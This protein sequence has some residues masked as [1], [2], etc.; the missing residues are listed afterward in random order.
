MVGFDF[1]LSSHDSCQRTI[2]DVIGHSLI[3]LL[4]CCC[5]NQLDQPIPSY[6]NCGMDRILNTPLH[7]LHYH[8]CDRFG[9]GSGRLRRH[10]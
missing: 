2:R 5:S 10:V 8:A 9:R 6:P 4:L 7:C 1:F 3:Q